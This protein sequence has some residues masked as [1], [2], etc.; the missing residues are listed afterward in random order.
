MTG[1]S[2][3]DLIKWTVQ[4]AHRTR[5]AATL[6]LVFLAGAAVLGGELAL[7]VSS[8]PAGSALAVGALAPAA[9]LWRRVSRWRGSGQRPPKPEQSDVDGS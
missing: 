4:S 9:A 3:P 6:L 7:A 8:A 1:T 5:N 2:V